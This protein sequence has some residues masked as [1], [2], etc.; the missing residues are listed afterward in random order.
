MANIYPLILS[1]LVGFLCGFLISIPVGPINVTI[2]NEGVRRGFIWALLI[3]FGAVTMEVIYCSLGFAGF[4]SFL[5]SKTFKAAMELISFILMLFLGFKYLTAPSIPTTSKSADKIEEKL[6]PHSAFMIGF[7]RVLGNPAV[8]LFWV[9]IAAA[10]VSHDLV[11]E[12][13]LSKAACISGVGMGAALWFLLLSYTISLR[14][15]QISTKALLRMS[16]IS[17]VFL[18]GFAAIIGIRIILLLSHHGNLISNR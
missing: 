6:H 3:G 1:W 12:T 15:K 13:L 16:H 11:D 5:V 17:G 8:L 7:V 14:H 18:L 9:V 10:F 2:I 4:A